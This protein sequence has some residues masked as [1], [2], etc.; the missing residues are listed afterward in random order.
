M[1][2][3][4]SQKKLDK[5]KDREFANQFRKNIEGYNNKHDDIINK[6]KGKIT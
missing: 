1:K 6:H 2:R 5:E 3:K 4:E